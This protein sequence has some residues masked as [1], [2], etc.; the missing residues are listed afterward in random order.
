MTLITL[1]GVIAFILRFFF[2]EFDC[3]ADHSVTV[4]EDTPIMSVNI[5]FQFQSS[6]LGRRFFYDFGAI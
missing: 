3:F 6:I 1:N 2:T 4:V 5:V